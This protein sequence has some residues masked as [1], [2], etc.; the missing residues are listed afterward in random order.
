MAKVYTGTSGWQ[1]DNW[2]FYPA[3]VPKDDWL[4]VYGDTFAT[5]EVNNSF[6]QLPSASTLRRWRDTTPDEFTF[7]LKANR[8][9]T[10]LKKLKDPDEPVQNLYDRIEAL[11]DKLGPILFQCPPNW[12]QNVERLRHFLGCLS[13]AHRH[14]FEFRDPTWFNAATYDALRDHNAA[15]CLYELG[16]MTTPT[17]LTADF[18]YVRLHGPAEKYVGRYSD[19]ALAE[20]ADAV[21]NWT[22]AGRDVYVFFNNTAG[23]GHAPHDAQRFQALLAES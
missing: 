11:G 3:S 17:E 6:Y 1:H 9:I 16:G 2:D 13:D 10:H 14:V 15:F 5:V 12:H 22:E 4:S 19:A 21:R 23:E 18:V 8:Y 20:W 7:A